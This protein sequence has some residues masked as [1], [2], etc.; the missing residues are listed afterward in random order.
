M[1]NDELTVP[2]SNR[3]S[4]VS[5]FPDRKTYCTH[6]EKNKQAKKKLPKNKNPPS[7]QSTHRWT[8][9][10]GK[11]PARANPLVGGSS[12][13]RNEHSLN[14]FS[15]FAWREGACP[16]ESSSTWCPRRCIHKIASKCSDINM[17]ER[18]VKRDDVQACYSGWTVSYL[19]CSLLVS[20]QHRALDS[21][22]VRGWVKCIIVIIII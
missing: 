17:V 19:Q 7:D 13:A 9:I 11:H 4:T 15:H 3:Q 18:E 1:F 5:L 2:P 8:P 6:R 14:A 22:T 12:R 21:L 16:G 10:G 20:P